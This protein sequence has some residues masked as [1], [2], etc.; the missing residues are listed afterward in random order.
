MKIALSVYPVSSHTTQIVEIAL[1]A[2]V[3]WMVVQAALTLLHVF[4]APKILTTCPQTLVSNVPKATLFAL[5]ATQLPASS[6]LSP[7]SSLQ[8]AAAQVVLLNAQNVQILQL[9]KGVLQDSI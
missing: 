7:I 6:V 2:I 3:S 5:T 9:A 1:T 4:L 8:M